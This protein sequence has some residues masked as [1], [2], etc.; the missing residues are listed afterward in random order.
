MTDLL[1]YNSAKI[2]HSNDYSD[3]TYVA[4]MY[5]AP[6][7]LS[8][9][10]FCAWA[11]PG[12]ILACLNTAGRA[13][14]FPPIAIAR[15]KRSD[16]FNNNRRAF[17]AQ[18]IKEI[19]AHVRRA[20]RKGLRPAVRLNGTSDLLWERIF[21]D[22]FDTFPEVQFY[23]Y[24]KYPQRFRNNLPNNYHLTFS[25]SERDDSEAEALAWLHSGGNVAI[26]FDTPK[27]QPLPESW[28]GYQVIDADIHDERF[29]D[30]AGSVAGLRA[31]GKAIN[32]TSG[33]V[34]LAQAA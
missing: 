15:K 26:V 18:L 5:L 8:G 22:I 12:C 17:K 19:A 24:T 14:I 31:K 29:K 16:L 30:P 20:Q 33:F 7:K 11:S 34:Q 10:N 25:L 4:I 23:D 28:N 32:D 9:K 2:E 3:D 6:A 27:G 21:P 1:T 13:A